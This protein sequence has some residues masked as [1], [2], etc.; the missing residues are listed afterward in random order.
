[1][2]SRFLTS[3]PA[4]RAFGSAVQSPGNCPGPLLYPDET[5][6]CTWMERWVWNKFLGD[7]RC[8]MPQG[9]YANPFSKVSEPGSSSQLKRP[10]KSFG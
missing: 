7:R 2:D 5:K 1:M 8:E 9:R 4:D 3:V 6:I 10:T